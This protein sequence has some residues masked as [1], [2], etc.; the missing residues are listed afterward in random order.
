M[1]VGAAAEREVLVHTKISESDKRTDLRIL[2]GIAL[3]IRIYP[4]LTYPAGQTGLKPTIRLVIVP[5]THVMMIAFFDDFLVD[6]DFGS[7]AL[8]LGEGLAIGVDC[9]TGGLD[10]EAA[11]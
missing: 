1:V 3:T 4:F 2:A 10:F 9:T 11:G 8:F 6:V 5:F 7:V